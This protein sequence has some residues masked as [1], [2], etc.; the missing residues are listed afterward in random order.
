MGAPGVGP[1]S[2]T[3]GE[4]AQPSVGLFLIPD[5]SSPE[6]Y[7]MAHRRTRTRAEQLGQGLAE[8]ALILGLIAIFVIAALTFLGTSIEGLLSTVSAA[9]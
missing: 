1:L 3:A 7:R 6:A 2:H 9:L 5:L 4:A 8:Y